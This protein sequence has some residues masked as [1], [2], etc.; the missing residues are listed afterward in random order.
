MPFKIYAD[1]ESKLPPTAENETKNPNISY[2]KNIKIM[3]HLVMA[4]NYY[5]LMNNTV[6]LIN[7]T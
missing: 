3:L 2:T 5:A 4:T 7:F 1:F 6:S